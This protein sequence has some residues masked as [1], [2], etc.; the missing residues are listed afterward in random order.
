[1]GAQAARSCRRAG[2]SR[3]GSGQQ[4][5]VRTS[6]NLPCCGRGRLD[7]DPLTSWLLAMNKPQ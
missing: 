2:P 4:E 1:M 5:Q 6:G 3:P 7:V